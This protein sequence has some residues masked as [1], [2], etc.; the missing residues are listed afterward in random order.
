V[1]VERDQVVAYTKIPCK[2]NRAKRVSIFCGNS[3]SS[4]PYI[5]FHVYLDKKD[6]LS[7]LQH[8]HL[9]RGPEVL[10]VSNGEKSKSKGIVYEV[11]RQRT[12]GIK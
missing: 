1:K 10:L 9:R 2:V 8:H 12:K 11:M 6:E 5:L 3:S 4:K 7:G